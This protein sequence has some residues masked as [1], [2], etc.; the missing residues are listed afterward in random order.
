MKA[1]ADTLGIARSNLAQRQ[2]KPSR[3]RGPLP[4]ARGRSPPATPAQARG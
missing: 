2:G 3:P 4:E 1:V